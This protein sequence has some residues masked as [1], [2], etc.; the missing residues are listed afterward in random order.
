MQK[1]QIKK[2]NFKPIAID[3]FCGGGGLSVG[4]KQAGFQIVAAVE[5]NEPAYRTYKA[6]HRKVKVFLQ[7][8]TCI[9]GKEL[10][11][12]SPTHNIDLIAGCPPCQGFSSLTAKY[13]KDDPR[14][15]LIL[16]MLRIIKEVNPKAVMLENVPGLIIRGN[17]IFNYFVTELKKLNYVVNY[18]VLQVADFGVPQKRKRLVLL[19]GKNFAI[20]IPSPQYSET[21]INRLKKWRTVRDFIYKLASPVNWK[22]AQNN[23]GPAA[24]SWNVVRDITEINK[25]RL[26]YALPGAP[27]SLIPDN[28]RPP[29]HRN[30]GGFSNVYGRLSWDAPSSTITGGCTTPSKGRFGHPTELRTISVREAALL[31]TF[32]K[33]Y[34]FATTKIDEACTIIGNA[35]PC[36]FAKAVSKQCYVALKQHSTTK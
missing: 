33:N 21:G 35:L 10:L 5:L 27:R 25:M 15:K 36:L 34:K 18:D 13:K 4:L 20:N 24:F 8:I 12:T 11:Q 30:N 26:S 22:Y 2:K 3:L 14:N 32:P 23:G 17:T 6:N 19:A 29:C 7:D 28:L 16:E 1:T 31:Q 9:T